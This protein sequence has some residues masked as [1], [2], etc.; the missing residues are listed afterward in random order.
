[1]HTEEGLPWG[2]SW[3]PSW[4]LLFPLLSLV[5]FK[6][7]ETQCG[8]QWLARPPCGEVGKCSADS[9]AVWE[10]GVGSLRRKSLLPWFQNAM[11]SPNVLLSA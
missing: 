5:K 2:Q 4:V 3:G 6:I 1:M 11:F 9:R 7:Q 8:E 10:V